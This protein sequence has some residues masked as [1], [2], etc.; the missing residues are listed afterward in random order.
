MAFLASYYLVEKSFLRETKR[1][2]SSCVKSA[3]AHDLRAATDLGAAT[4]GADQIGGAQCRRR[5]TK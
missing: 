3:A 1:F 2:K 4:N 5:T